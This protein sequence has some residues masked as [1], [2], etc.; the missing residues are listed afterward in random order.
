MTALPPFPVD[1]ETLDLLE[2]AI[3]TPGV[4]VATVLEGLAGDA[5]EDGPTYHW[6]DAMGALIT[7]VR[8]LRWQLRPV[9]TAPELTDDQVEAIKT[10]WLAMHAKQGQRPTILDE[11]TR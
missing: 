10:A 2:L 11:E 8:Q 9:I 5:P 6:C 1:D 4:S 3:T 7:E